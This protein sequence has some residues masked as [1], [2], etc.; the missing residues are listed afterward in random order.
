MTTCNDVCYIESGNPPIHAVIKKKKRMFLRSMWR[1]R[2]HLD[3]DPFTHALKIV[4][5]ARYNTK[6]YLQGL[7]YNDIDDVESEMRSQ[8]LTMQHSTIIL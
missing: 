4:M 8:V 3:D 2:S 1:E 5:R 7:I 6:R